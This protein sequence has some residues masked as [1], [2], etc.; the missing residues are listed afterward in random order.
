[1]T[2]KYFFE[3]ENESN[4]AFINQAILTKQNPFPRNP[5]TS[6]DNLPEFCLGRTEEIGIIKN[7]IE[8]VSNDPGNKSAWIPI[9]G[10]G[11][12]GKST[13][14]LYVYNKIRIGQS[15][16]LDVDHLEGTYINIPADPRYLTI[17]YIYK[18]IIEDL[19]DSPE[20]YPYFLGFK[21]VN[22]LCK[23]ILNIEEIKEEFE[24][25]FKNILSNISSC[26]TYKQFLIKIKK[27]APKFTNELIEF[28]NEYDYLILSEIKLNLNY[29]QNLI[30]LVS[31]NKK[32]RRT[33]CE[34]ILGRTIKDD[35]EA[36]EMIENFI[37]TTNFLFERSCLMIIMD[38][39]ENLSLEEKTFREFF[40]FLQAFRNNINNC[41]LLTIGST[42]FWEFFRRVI[43]MSEWNMIEGF[44]YEELS[45][46]SLSGEDASRILMRHMSEFWKK[47]GAKYSPIG[48]DRNFPFSKSSFRYIYEISDRNLRDSLKKC[49][50][51]IEKF[52]EIRQ[53][54]YYKNLETTIYNLRPLSVGI[55]LFENEINFLL[56]FLSKFTD[57]N[58]LSRKVENGLVRAFNEIK[59]NQEKKYLSNVE[60]EPSITLNDGTLCKPDVYLTLFGQ[61]SIQNLKCAEIQ[62]KTSFPTNCVSLNHARSS[63]N[64]L[65]EGK[66]H[67]L[68]FITL[69]P[70]DNKLLQE[71]NK[72]KSRVGRITPLENEEPAYLALLISE[73]S[74]IFFKKEILD[75]DTYIG[76]LKKIGFEIPELFEEI[77]NIPILD[78]R[79]PEEKI[80]SFPTQPKPIPLPVTPITP[81]KKIYNP[82]ELEGHIIK[83]FESIGLIKKKQ[84]IVD[85]MKKIAGSISV[86]NNS[87]SSLQKLNII[88]YSRSKP[89][90]WSL[91]K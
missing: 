39:L 86:I 41:L 72:Y 21:F 53:I 12:T 79:K 85:E 61:K 64:M 14:A 60:H 24:N 62:V 56:K 31:G 8:K 78:I 19:G 69:S 2:Q 71:L 1:M 25:I 16:D 9:N 10:D 76:I 13:I 20:T 49:N 38:N 54:L 18:K 83:F 37:K 26:E 81:S 23:I 88:Q 59:I 68:Y 45:L 43:S 6:K 4:N 84:D 27:K 33:A 51:I 57:R 75:Y 74:K 42:K 52:K 73:F 91:K 44:K 11:G 28:V 89:Q 48:K 17:S 5:V 65:K 32:L 77:K 90:G 40:K 67:Y 66:I 3:T 46:V 34:F 30:R 47:N 80:P 58:N 55:Y 29:I 82:K 50:R 35:V 87:I 70:L 22:K 7:A 63:I 15:R 36:R